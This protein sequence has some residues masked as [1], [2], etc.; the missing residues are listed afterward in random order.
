[1]KPHGFLVEFL[2]E[3]AAIEINGNLNTKNGE[4]SQKLYTIYTQNELPLVYWPP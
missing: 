4:I 3:K 2:N 1:M